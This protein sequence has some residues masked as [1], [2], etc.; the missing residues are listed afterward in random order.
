[1]VQ[2]ISQG[3][4]VVEQKFVLSPNT[5]FRDEVSLGAAI[6]VYSVTVG[7]DSVAIVVE[8]LVELP[9]DQELAK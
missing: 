3:L 5:Y 7:S 9:V 1:M 6:S 2:V 4:Q 8:P